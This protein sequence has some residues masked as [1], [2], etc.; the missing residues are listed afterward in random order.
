MASAS[1]LPTLPG[2]LFEQT[3]MELHERATG[4][5]VIVDVTGPV[6]REGDEA[7]VLLARLRAILDRGDRHILLNVVTVTYVDS[8]L[9]GSIIQAY[10]AAIRYGGAV[11]L[12]HVSPRFRQLLAVTKLDRVLPAFESEEVAVASFPPLQTGDASPHG[13]T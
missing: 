8:L 6:E 12:L 3:R 9:L 5:V 2:V 7:L 4:Q 10:V 1:F 13:Q 11:K